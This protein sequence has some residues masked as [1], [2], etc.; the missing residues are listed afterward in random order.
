M[1]KL[2]THELFP[3]DSTPSVTCSY[4]LDAL[5]L[6][7]VCLVPRVRHAWM[8]GVAPIVAFWSIVFCGPFLFQMLDPDDNRSD[9]Y[10]YAWWLGV[11][12]DFYLV[13]SLIGTA[14]GGIIASVLVVATV[15]V[16][17][18]LSLVI[19]IIKIFHLRR[20]SRVLDLAL[21]VY[22]LVAAIVFE[23]QTWIIAVAL[24]VKD[25][26]MLQTLFGVLKLLLIHNYVVRSQALRAYPSADVDDAV[27]VCLHEKR[28]WLDGTAKFETLRE[29][30]V[31]VKVVRRSPVEIE[32]CSPFEVLKTWLY[33]RGSIKIDELDD[34]IIN[35]VVPQETWK[36]TTA[37]A[38]QGTTNTPGL[39]LLDPNAY[40]CL[41]ARASPRSPKLEY[42]LTVSEETET[43]TAAVVPPT[44]TQSAKSF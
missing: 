11:L 42:I 6:R 37:A 40:D 31:W 14:V 8:I 39:V 1:S 18:V 12:G 38:L 7:I 13:T 29:L 5:L 3:W 28:V 19:E 21:L 22:S 34:W 41:S 27:A 10:A 16:V 35:N 9:Y 36:N 4:A 43:T 32:A 44:D 20:L 25:S 15:A 23:R 30:P 2:S 24:F 26:F 17:I 33:N